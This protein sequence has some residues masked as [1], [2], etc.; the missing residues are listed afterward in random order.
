MLVAGGGG[1]YGGTNWMAADVPFMWSAI[2]NQET[3]PHFNVVEGWRKTADLTNVHLGQVKAYRENLASV[4][5]P[6][7][8]AASAAYLARLDRLIADLS[9]THEAAS[10]NYTAFSTVTLTLSLARNKLKPILEEY[11]ANAKAMVDWEAK[12]EG[13]AGQKGASRAGQK[14]PVPSSRQEELNNQARAIMYDLSSTVLS[15]QA[16]LKKPVPYDPNREYRQGSEF[17][18]GEANSSTGFAVPPLIPPPGASTGGGISSTS[19]SASHSTVTPVQAT[20][21]IPTNPGP[22]GAGPVLGGAG[23]TP[24]ITP[25]TTGLSPVPGP[26][27][28]PSPAPSGLM[29]GVISPSG[30]PG[31]TPTSGFLPNGN[32][33]PPGGVT[34]P[35]AASGPAGRMTMPSGGVI[36]ATPGSGMIG[37]MP[38]AAPGT[39]AGG[40]TRANPVGGVIGQARAGA[41]VNNGVGSQSAP[42]GSPTGRGHGWRDDSNESTRWDPDNPWVTDEGVDPIVLPPEDH[43][44]IDPGPAIGYSR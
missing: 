37:Q 8:S 2:A 15:G 18:N 36:G 41:S 4:W 21:A 33:V 26:G 22:V 42:F 10:A 24:A 13:A 27:P 32:K 7:K 16:A 14:P 11:Q 28:L 20:T 31:L 43:G 40:S 5:P 29:P 25:P 12:Q 34:K 23:P 19:N 9:E 1:G 3:D 39:R 35:G 17:N 38:A 6:A 30:S 44:P